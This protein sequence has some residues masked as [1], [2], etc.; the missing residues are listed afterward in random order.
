[1]STDAQPKR[2]GWRKRR[3]ELRAW[4]EDALRATLEAALGDPEVR[5]VNELRQR[6]IGCVGEEVAAAVIGAVQGALS[7]PGYLGSEAPLPERRR[8]E[9]LRGR[10]VDA[11]VNAAREGF[12]WLSTLARIFEEA[13]GSAP[14][15]E[16]AIDQLIDAVVARTGLD[17]AWYQELEEPLS[18]LADSLGRPAESVGPVFD[19]LTSVV[20]SSWIEP[21]GSLRRFGVRRLTGGITGDA[22]R[23]P[24]DLAERASK[25]LRPRRPRLDEALDA[26]K[27]RDPQAALEALVSRGLLDESWLD[28]QVRARGGINRKRAVTFNPKGNTA[29]ELLALLGSDA[30]AVTRAEALALEVARRLA[31]FHL[32]RAPWKPV[33]VTEAYGE[34]RLFPRYHTVSPPFSNA[35]VSATLPSGRDVDSLVRFMVDGRRIDRA[36]AT[37]LREAILAL[38]ERGADVQHAHSTRPDL[39]P[40]DRDTVAKISIAAESWT[41]LASL[42]AL[43]PGPEQFARGWT[44]APPLVPLRDLASPLDPIVELYETGYALHGFD[45]ERGL[46]V[47]LAPP[48]G[49]S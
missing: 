35:V 1:M 12:A 32:Q 24:D 41:M 28:D 42:G 49:V 30:E 37:E 7:M 43:T 11:G 26:V 23:V 44:P 31:P 22:L 9:P 20:F 19:S 6:V 33:W 16:R 18:W 45:V 5:T 39:T 3:D 34:A 46:V 21:E 15:I 36:R 2:Y 27:A 4:S 40:S 29:R 14:S 38:T 10:A 48:L 17:D 25:L 13:D 8:D 47:M